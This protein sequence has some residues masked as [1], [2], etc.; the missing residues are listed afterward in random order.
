M[1]SMQ[2]KKGKPY[3][4]ARS[5]KINNNENYGTVQ[6]VQEFFLK[7]KGVSINRR[8]A[9]NWF[10]I[11]K[12][13]PNSEVSISYRNFVDPNRELKKKRRVIYEEYG[14]VETLKD[15]AIS[16]N[17]NLKAL[18]IDAMLNTPF[19]LSSTA[20]RQFVKNP[21]SVHRCSKTKA[22]PSSIE[23]QK[24]K[25]RR[26]IYEKFGTVANLIEW[27]RINHITRYIRNAIIN[28]L[29]ESNT[30]PHSSYFKMLMTEESDDESQALFDLK[31][32]GYSSQTINTPVSNDATV[33]NPVFKSDQTDTRSDL[34]KSNQRQKLTPKKIIFHLS[35]SDEDSEPLCDLKSLKNK[36]K[37][38]P[39]KP[40]FNV[41]DSDEDSEPLF[42]MHKKTHIVER[43]PNEHSSMG[44]V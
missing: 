30:P 25:L 17:I 19:I 12:G 5:Y 32:Q 20:Y 38:V 18:L 8:D 7:I 33:P 31:K 1:K 43:I 2:R 16:K 42:D 27:A 29:V 13:L 39:K 6:K 41:S 14:T 22:H 36:Q 44:S 24:N 15:F 9:E 3:I 21:N 40:A 37:A 4:N 35:D 26:N 23:N 11:F 28:A 34:T 10:E